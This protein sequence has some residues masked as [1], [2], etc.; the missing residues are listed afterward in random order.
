VFRHLPH[1]RAL[2]LHDRKLRHRLAL[3][4]TPPQQNSI[5]CVASSFFAVTSECSSLILTPVDPHPEGHPGPLK[6]FQLRARA[7]SMLSPL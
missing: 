5:V 2:P 1:R 3:P 4:I 7:Q 6:T